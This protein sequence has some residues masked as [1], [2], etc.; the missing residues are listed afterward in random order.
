MFN[1]KA[2]LKY[3]YRDSE[4]VRWYSLKSELIFLDGKDV[5]IV[6]R[7]TFLFDC[8]SVPNLLQFIYIPTGRYTEASI[9]HDWCYGERN[10]SRLKADNLFYKAMKSS[11]VN[12]FT[13]TLF[14]LAVRVG[15]SSHR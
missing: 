6:P 1:T 13:R 12:I 7:S 10:I 2:K 3:E 15:G 14:Y 11:K 8:A 4:G 9:L 5:Y